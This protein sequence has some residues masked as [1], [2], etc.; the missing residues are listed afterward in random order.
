MGE[1][2]AFMSQAAIR[3]SH[4]LDDLELQRFCRVGFS[5]GSEGEPHPG[6]APGSCL[7]RQYLA[8]LGL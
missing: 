1:V 5:G 6:L 8:F 2:S 7:L 4:M 3:K